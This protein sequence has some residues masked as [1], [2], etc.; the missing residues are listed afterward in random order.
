MHRSLSD[1]RRPL[2]SIILAAA[3]V[4]ASTVFATAVRADDRHSRVELE[5]KRSRGRRH[6]NGEGL[7]LQGG[8][9]W[10]IHL[11]IDDY[12]WRRADSRRDE[13]GPCIWVSARGQEDRVGPVRRGAHRHRPRE[14]C[15]RRSI[16]R[17][18]RP[19]PK[20]TGR[21]PLSA[22]DVL[23]GRPG[24]CLSRGR[25]GSVWDEEALVAG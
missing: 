4:L 10:V 3:G 18:D 14:H 13:R 25:A 19:S 2:L 8:D 7:G 1:V 23:L 22:D 17:G 6:N 21:R 5:C 11:H 20:R 16:H 9:R 12:D 24:R 15:T